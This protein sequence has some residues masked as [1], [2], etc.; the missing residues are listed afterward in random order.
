MDKA[1]WKKRKRH[2]SPLVLKSLWFQKRPLKSGSKKGS[3]KLKT[4]S[5]LK[6]S[7]AY[8]ATT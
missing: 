7:K 3:K 6:K 5:H 2:T 4:Q 1:R 8:K